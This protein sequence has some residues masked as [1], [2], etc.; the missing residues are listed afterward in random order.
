MKSDFVKQTD[1]KGT[2]IIEGEKKPKM[3][4]SVKRFICLVQLQETEEET[5]KLADWIIKKLSS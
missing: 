3:V 5:Q 4:F 1:R 2:Y